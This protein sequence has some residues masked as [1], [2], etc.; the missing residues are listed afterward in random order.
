[1][2]EAFDLLNGSSAL[3]ASELFGFYAKVTDI[4]QRTGSVRKLCVIKLAL[5][6]TNVNYYLP[7]N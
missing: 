6:V 4:A 7:V 2:H 3:H 1:M 5:E